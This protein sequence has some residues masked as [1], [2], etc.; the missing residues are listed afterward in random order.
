MIRGFQSE[1]LFSESDWHLGPFRLRSWTVV[2][3]GI[4]RSEIVVS[5]FLGFKFRGLI[6]PKDSKAFEF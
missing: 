3:D 5:L 4:H 1:I 6:V 2:D